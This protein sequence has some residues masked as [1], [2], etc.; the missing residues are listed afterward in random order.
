MINKTMSSVKL[1]ITCEI[2]QISVL[3]MHLKSVAEYE[4]YT[5]I[6]EGEF[7]C[8]ILLLQNYFE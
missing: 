3:A 2:I 7:Y 1:Y 5:N 6:F 4:I 8:D